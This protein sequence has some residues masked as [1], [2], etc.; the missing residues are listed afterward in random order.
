VPVLFMTGT[1]DYGQGAR[2][3]DWRRA[4]FEHVS[5][6][7]DYLVTLNGAGHMTFGGIGA[8][9]GPTGSDAPSKG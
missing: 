1:R 7:D 9:G 5:G 4:G 8:G 2:S 3:A 6:V